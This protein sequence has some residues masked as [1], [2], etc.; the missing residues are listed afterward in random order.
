MSGEMLEDYHRFRNPNRKSGQAGFFLPGPLFYYLLTALFNVFP[1]PR[2][3]D[4]QRSFSHAGQALDNGMNVLL[5]PEGT[6]SKD[7]QMASFRPGIGMLVKQSNAPVLP[8]A[9]RGLRD[10]ESG[11]RKWFRSGQLEI[12]IGQPISFSPSDREASITAQLQAAV[13]QL[14]RP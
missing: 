14:L 9:I 5:F 12:R 7:G 10:L 13:E 6:R 1:L 11:N 4:I 8:I 2:Q 3:R